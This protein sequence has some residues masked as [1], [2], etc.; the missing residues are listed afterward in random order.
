M[1]ED[2]AESGSGKD[3]QRSKSRSA[4]NAGRLFSY[5]RIL[6]RWEGKRRMC[7]TRGDRY[8]LLRWA[9][10][11]EPR[12]ESAPITLYTGYML[13]EL[14]SRRDTR[15]ADTLAGADILIDEPFVKELAE[16]ARVLRLDQPCTNPIE[17]LREFG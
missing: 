16:N 17:E 2:A 9:P 8:P 10:A 13:E 5:G 4:G 7:P 3:P 12:G 11:A 15:V 14:T 1:A 6:A